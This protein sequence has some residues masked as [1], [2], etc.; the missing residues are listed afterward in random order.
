MKKK[1]FDQ[2][3]RSIKEAGAIRRKTL[4]PGRVFHVEPHNEIGKVRAALGLSQGKFATLL[5]ISTATLQNWEQGR[6]N[7]SG[8]AR[9][10]LKIAARH[11]EVLLETAA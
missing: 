3:C 9:V 5:G 8:A 11:P 1:L 6:R 10:L 4:K 2:L 7:P